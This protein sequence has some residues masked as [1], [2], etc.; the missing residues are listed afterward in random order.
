MKT[1]PLTSFIAV[2]ALLPLA[3]WADDTRGQNTIQREA[4]DPRP[5]ETRSG[6]PTPRVEETRDQARDPS[7]QREMRE[8]REDTTESLHT[9]TTGGAAAAA[10][11]ERLSQEQVEQRV[12]ASE[13]IGTKVVDREGQEVGKVKDIG[14]TAVAPQL[15][16][17]ISTRAVARSASESPRTE[18]TAGSGLSQPWT[19]QTAGSGTKEARVLV[20]PSRALGAGDALVAIP[21]TQLHREG[22]ALRIDLSREELRALVG[23]QDASRVSM[24]E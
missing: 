22:D 13:L 1:H 2:G 7:L 24:N 19:Q 18:R 17:D 11:V 3:A 15:G 4:Y 8:S 9:S 21:A 6:P 14:L 12:T 16:P 23:E 10:G 20:R 5:S